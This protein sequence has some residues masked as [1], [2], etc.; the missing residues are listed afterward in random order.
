MSCSRSSQWRSAAGHDQRK[1]DDH[2][3]ERKRVGYGTTEHAA[4]HGERPSRRKRGDDGNQSSTEL[5]FF[6]LNEIDAGFKDNHPRVPDLSADIL[7]KFPSETYVGAYL[8]HGNSKTIFV[9]KSRSRHKGKFDG[10]VLKISR[11]HDKEPAVMRQAQEITARLLHECYGKDGNDVYHCWV[12]ER[13]IPLH[14]LAL[15]LDTCNKERCVLAACRC[16][17]RAARCRLLLSDCHYYNLGVRITTSDAAHEVVIIDVGSRGIRESVPSKGDVNYGMKK[18]WKWTTNEIKTSSKSTQELWRYQQHLEDAITYLDTKWELW[19][20]LTETAIQTMV[21]E[22]DITMKCSS[23]LCEF[24]ESPQGKLLKLIGSSSVE[25]MGG[26][27]NERLSEIC[28]R[29]AE[30]THTT[31]D[32]EEER[33]LTEMYE[34]IRTQHHTSRTKSSDVRRR[35]KEEIEDIMAFWWQLQQ[36]RRSYLERHH[37]LDTADE[38]LNETDIQR[39]KR[40]WEDFDMW[41]DLTKKQQK[42]KRLSSI[43]NAVLNKR[44]GWATVANAIIKYRMPQLPHLIRESD[45]VTEHIQII[46]RFCCDLLAWMKKF[47]GAAVAYWKTETY[48]RAQMISALPPVS[49]T[50]SSATA[51][52]TRSSSSESRQAVVSVVERFEAKWEDT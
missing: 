43:Y 33:V 5:Q 39:V 15:D 6:K 47:A 40:N 8:S 1:Y 21:I 44:S 25:W 29:I 9:L 37:R 12:A 35:T 20:Y 19:P 46:T 3:G 51:E 41:Y 42:S 14:R 31:F 16:I 50:P 24:L 28:M 11:E 49:K 52:E 26:V 23:T 4:V 30:E 2:A 7:V 45:R 36:W 48:E 34:R 38:I 27:W 17:A 13:C 18:L 22:Q 32:A 10:E